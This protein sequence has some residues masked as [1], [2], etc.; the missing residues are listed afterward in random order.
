M[1]AK[2]RAY[3]STLS[4]SS[5]RFVALRSLFLAKVHLGSSIVIGTVDHSGARDGRR[6]N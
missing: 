6:V 5:C 2:G 4:C 3:S 1:G